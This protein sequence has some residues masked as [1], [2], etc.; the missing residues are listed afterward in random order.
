MLLV[1]IVE[2]EDD[3]AAGLHHA[4]GKNEGGAGDRSHGQVFRDE[5]VVQRRVFQTAPT[6]S[7]EVKRKSI[8]CFRS[9]ERHDGL[10][11]WPS[12]RGL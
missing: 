2:V 7:K 3:A 11:L 5:D 8:L 10:L 6:N 1:S 4:T 12:I 9:E